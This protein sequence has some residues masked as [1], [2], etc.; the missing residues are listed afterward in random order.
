MSAASER[1]LFPSG[2]ILDSGL[3][4]YHH[5]LALQAQLLSPGK[6]YCFVGGVQSVA[7]RHSLLKIAA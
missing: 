2:A 7:R 5:A 6:N 1:M 3:R 4:A